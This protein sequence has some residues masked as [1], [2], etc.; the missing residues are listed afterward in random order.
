MERWMKQF[1]RRSLLT[2]V[3]ALSALAI[4]ARVHSTADK[5]TRVR[6][7]EKGDVN[8]PLCTTRIKPSLAAPNGLR[9]FRV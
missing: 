5:E 4:S 1:S 3:T 6:R 9:W 2:T 7:L 8:L